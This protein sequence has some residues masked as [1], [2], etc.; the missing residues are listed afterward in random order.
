MCC[1]FVSIIMFKLYFSASDYGFAA[2]PS[3]W[4]LTVGSYDNTTATS[5]NWMYMGYTEWI[6]S[7]FYATNSGLY[8]IDYDGKLGIENSGW[9]FKV[10]PVLYLKASVSY[11]GGVGTQSDLIV[12]GD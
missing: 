10:R 8:C 3:A 1:F 11:S 7:R 5:T 4:T 2:S 12:I 9:G 6:I